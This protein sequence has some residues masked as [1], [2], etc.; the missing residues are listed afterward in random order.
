[1]LLSPQDP[2]CV[3]RMA[4]SRGGLSGTGEPG[5][6]ERPRRGEQWWKQEKQGWWDP[7]AHLCRG[8]GPGTEDSVSPGVEGNRAQGGSP[9]AKQTCHEES[10]RWLSGAGGIELFVEGLFFR[11]EKQQ[12]PRPDHLA[13]W[14]V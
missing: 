13:P 11:Q 14:Q 9:P 1:M 8:G 12:F 4:V 7:G 6:R 5:S 3:G 10:A 2:C